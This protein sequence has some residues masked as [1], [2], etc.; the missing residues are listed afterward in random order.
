MIEIYKDINGYEG[1]YQVSNF[2]Y[3]KNLK[4]NKILNGTIARNGYR[5]VTLSKD[6]K[7]KKHYV[8]RLVAESFIKHNIENNVVNHKNFNRLDNNVE[9]LEWC[10]TKYNLLYSYYNGRIPLPPPQ[11]PKKIIRNDGK[12]YKS[13]EEAGKDMKIHPSIICNQLKGRIK[14]A[15]GYI[16]KYLS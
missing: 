9:N 11:K 1:L 5:V 3:V 7:H 12:I 13:L 2:G 14:T 8:H 16:F 10:S 4:Y 15:K 6:K